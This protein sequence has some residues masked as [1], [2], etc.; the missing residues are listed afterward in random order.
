MNDIFDKKA[1]IWCSRLNGL[2]KKKGYTQELFLKEY[3]YRYGKGTQANVSRWLR[4]GNATRKSGSEAK[5]GFPSY[6]SMANIANIFGVT[7]GYLTGETDCETFEMEQVSKFIGVDEETCKAIQKIASGQHSHHLMQAEAAQYRAAL[8]C[9]FMADSFSEFV[10]E[11]VDYSWHIYRKKHP[12]NHL[13][14]AVGCITNEEIRELAVQCMDY[15]SYSGDETFDNFSDND[16]APT[17]E[18][19]DAIEKLEEA[20]WQDFKE[21]EENEQQIKVSEYELQKIY[22]RLIEEITSD[23]HLNPIRAFDDSKCESL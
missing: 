2:M 9:L 20:R 5:I 22:F 23:E 18:L 7:V 13:E 11:F 10:K 16:V 6:E 1:K 3:R 15:S 14:E 21:K 4:V 19:L 8:K 17:K 12:V